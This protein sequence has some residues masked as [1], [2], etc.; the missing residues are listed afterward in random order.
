MEFNG[1]YEHPIG[2]RPV[3]TRLSGRRCRPGHVPDQ[4]RR[5]HF[6][7]DIRPPK[8]LAALCISTVS[9]GRRSGDKPLAA[10]IAARR[11]AL[12]RA[13]AF[14]R[15]ML[16]DVDIRPP[17]RLAAL[18]IFTVSV[19]GRSGDNPLPAGIAAR[20]CALKCASAFDRPMLSD[21]DI[22]PPKRLAAL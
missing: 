20:R 8:R 3:R 11:C 6:S 1:E 14:D 10:G 21:V 15:T 2:W 9:V 19:G 5:A 18:C 12:K 7:V 16:S 22:R 4:E 17:K 13:S